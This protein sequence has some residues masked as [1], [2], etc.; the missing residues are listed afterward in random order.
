M[1]TGTAIIGMRV[2]RQF[3]R[4]TSTTTP[5]SATASS[6]LQVENSEFRANFLGVDSEPQG[7]ATVANVALDNVTVA[8]STSFGIFIQ[9]ASVAS[10]HGAVVVG[11]LRYPACSTSVSGCW[12]LVGIR[13]SVRGRRAGTL[14]CV[15]P[16]R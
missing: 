12:L 4:K 15:G 2:A 14:P 8:S 11:S 7:A 9:N 16:Q 5:T 10:V 3:C 6:T 13:V 1:A